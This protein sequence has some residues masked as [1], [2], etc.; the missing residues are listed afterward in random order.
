MFENTINKLGKK[1]IDRWIIEFVAMLFCVGIFEFFY[2]WINRY[3]L[4]GYSAF[5]GSYELRDYFVQFIQ[6]YGVLFIPL[7]SYL[8][9]KYRNSNNFNTKK[10]KT[11]FTIFLISLFSYLI[12]SYH[13]YGV[14][15]WS[16]L[17][18]SIFIIILLKFNV[19]FAMSFS[20]LSFYM[21]N[22]FFEFQGLNF[23]YSFGTLLSYILVFGIYILILIELKIKV[24]KNIFFSFIPTVFMWIYFYPIWSLHGKDFTLTYLPYDLYVRLLTFPFFL[25]I[26]IIIYFTYRKHT[27]A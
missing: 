18:I 17:F 6:V 12:F 15:E 25:T 2:I 23:L 5:V 20:W 13:N 16:F 1:N 21:A 19:V 26:S 4:V 14:W 8:G 7:I 10:I 9:F 27:N 24:T 3:S 11:A 22:M